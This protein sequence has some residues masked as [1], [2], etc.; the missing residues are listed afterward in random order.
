MTVF[1]AVAANTVTKAAMAGA[2]G[3]W[4]FARRLIPGFALA[5]ATGAVALLAWRPG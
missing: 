4:S 5:L 1:L 3:G 2:L